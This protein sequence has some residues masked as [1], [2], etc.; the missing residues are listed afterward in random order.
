MSLGFELND[1]NQRMN[2]CVSK[3]SL[4]TEPIHILLLGSNFLPKEG[5]L[6]DYKASFSA[7]AAPLAKTVLQIV[8]FHNTFGGYLVFGVKETVKDKEFV[9]VETDLSQIDP[10]QLRNKTKE[11][12]GSNID[13]TYKVVTYEVDKKQHTVGL[14]HIPQRNRST[15][16]V[17]FIK[18]GPEKKP[19]KLVFQREQTY[20]R[21]Q[22]ECL[23][24]TQMKD[25]QSLFSKRNF[26]ESYG[27]DG[28]NTD[29][30][31][32]YFNHNLPE[33][34]LICSKFVG[35]EEVLSKL[36]EWL[37]DD[38]EYT[39][40][41]SGDGG[42]G[43]TSIAY[44]FCRSFIQ[45]P[46]TG[47]ERVLWLSVKEKQFSG[48]T[49]DYYELDSSDFIDL[50]SFLLCLADNCALDTDEYADL[51]VS[52]IKKELK[53]S[54]VEFPSIIV[55]DDIDSLDE[56]EQKKVVDACRHIGKDK[57]R[58]L[59]TTRK[60][61]AYS[62]DL[63]ID[64]P[65]F[66]LDDFSVY[67][68]SLIERYKLKH[69]SKKDIL[70]LHV[71][72]DGSPLLA[73]S[74]LR[75]F[76]QGMSLD[77][78]RKEW[79]GHAG[80]DARN[81]ALRREIDSLSPDAKRILLAIHY[82][83][84]C[85]YTE[86]KQS[87]GVAE[88]RLVGC[89]EE[90]QSLF[91]VNEP[92]LIEGEDRFSISNTTTL[93]VS[94]MITDMAF[95]HHKLHTTIKKMKTSHLSNKKV[96]NRRQ[97]GIAINQAMALLNDDRFADAIATVDIELRSKKNNPDLLLMKARC[98]FSMDKPKYDD[99]AKLLRASIENGQSKDLAFDLLFKCDKALDSAN[100]MID[101][102]TKAIRLSDSEDHNKWYERQARGFVTRAMVRSGDAALRDFMDASLALSNTLN[103]LGK[104]ER[105][106]RL[107]DLAVLHDLIWKRIENDQGYSW[108]SCFDCL[109]ELIK[110]GDVRSSMYWNAC[111]CIQEALAEPNPSDKKAE[112]CEICIDKFYK[113]LESRSK[114]DRKD[115]PFDDLKQSLGIDAV[116][117]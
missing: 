94:T 85:S 78:A 45:S 105:G 52:A 38:L 89:L 13:I 35:R 42:K 14:L 72:C 1:I 73:A 98:L 12:T 40:I 25:W 115:R 92:K 37:V 112:A 117:A 11:F 30:S 116:V 23:P 91:L 77:K 71:D 24:A 87:T 108:L 83:K 80:E 64:V 53:L 93:L 5:Y 62:S 110:S 96:G 7:D 106:K 97:V 32:L 44:E 79:K 27:L 86:L 90:L 104:L 107:N 111:R 39:K 16:P 69:I 76:K 31:E 4:G 3:A 65:G 50:D 99:A 47:Y 49:N 67:I 101:V 18:N 59:I 109:L 19:N 29:D 41:L 81:A 46:P 20:Y 9:Q 75:F 95:D 74:I 2:N 17:S 54:M 82:H 8:S 56:N 6:W 114:K 70:K 10:A 28:S 55:V 63:C 15:N 26:S 58:F 88:I 43:K 21:Y 102:A 66:P 100:G 113:L 33:R 36:W 34:H 22:D 48:I 103:Y 84:S 60:K 57:V 51:S 61:L 68:E